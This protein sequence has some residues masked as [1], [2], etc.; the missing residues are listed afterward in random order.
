[1]LG[2]SPR[3]VVRLHLKGFGS[4]HLEQIFFR[5]LRLKI[6]LLEALKSRGHNNYM[7]HPPVFIDGQKVCLA[8]L[9]RIRRQVKLA[10]S[11]NKTKVVDVDF[12]FSSHCYSR[13]LKDGEV[14]PEGQGV[15]DGS[16]ELPRPRVFDPERY[17]LS[18][19]LVD[20]IDQMIVSDSVVTKSRH[21]NFFRVDDVVVE[22]DESG[23]TVSYFIF[24][25]AKKV[26]DPGRPKTIIVTVESAY[27]EVD[28]IPNP[29]GQGSRSFG[30][31]LGEK[32][33]P[34]AIAAGKGK[35]KRKKS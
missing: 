31:M 34:L 1:M 35:K 11:G 3:P 32:W 29:I 13:G 25:H 5:L 16:K 19:G 8:H 12:R 4:F 26:E 18:K 22:R 14:A 7:N 23:Q 6:G 33:E 9:A 2:Q 17:E 15:P 10:L 24:M 20:M 28:D 21:E 27:A 30:E